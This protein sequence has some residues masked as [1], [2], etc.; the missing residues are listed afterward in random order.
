[1]ALKAV[2]GKSGCRVL[3]RGSWEGEKRR[4]VEGERKRSEWVGERK[5]AEDLT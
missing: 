4:E 3:G 1:M 2:S 5:R